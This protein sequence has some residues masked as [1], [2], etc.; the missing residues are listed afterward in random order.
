[1][2]HDARAENERDQGGGEDRSDDAVTPPRAHPADPRPVDR[3]EAHEIDER[4]QRDHDCDDDRARRMRRGDR[5]ERECEQPRRA[6]VALA[7]KHQSNGEDDQ[8]HE[9]EGQGRPETMPVHQIESNR[10]DGVRT[11]RCEA[12]PGSPE[13]ACGRVDAENRDRRDDHEPEP[14]RPGRDPVEDEEAPV[15]RAHPRWIGEDAI[16][17]AR[18]RIVDEESLLRFHLF[19]VE[20]VVPEVD[21]AGL[22]RVDDV[23]RRGGGEGEHG[24]ERSDGKRLAPATRLRPHRSRARRPDDRRDGDGYEDE[25]SDRKSNRDL[26]EPESRYRDRG[27]YDSERGDGEGGENGYSQGGARQ[28]ARHHRHERQ[29]AGGQQEQRRARIRSSDG[30]PEQRVCNE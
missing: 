21:P 16:R 18:E 30:D 3:S 19:R 28:G 9:D 12:G 7:A 11:R 20:Q 24:Q 25:C 8:R 29:A 17:F 27:Q 22:E 4:S 13:P 15:H 23:P 14:E 6:P 10:G 1:M 2:S 26:G 5:D